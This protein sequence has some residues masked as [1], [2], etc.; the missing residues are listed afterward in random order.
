[1]MLY[2]SEN[3]D[4]PP[5]VIYLIGAIAAIPIVGGLYCLVTSSLPA[6]RSLSGSRM[7][8]GE[9]KEE[10]KEI[11]RKID[12]IDSL[13][14]DVS[15]ARHHLEEGETQKALHWLDP[16]HALG[17]LKKSL[18][19]G[20]LTPIEF[21]KVG[22]AIIKIK[23]AVDSG[24]LAEAHALI[25]PLQEK[26]AEKAYT[27]FRE[28]DPVPEGYINARYEEARKRVVE[29]WRAKGYSEGLIEKAL[30]WADEWTKGIA[31]RFIKDPVMRATVEETL[32][33]EALA[34]S[35]RW[36]EAMVK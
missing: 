18:Q 9:V 36:I 31:R 11:L 15:V 19:S 5:W 34:L 27:T 21:D 22:E 13:Y 35:T 25:V 8:P 6:G 23:D 10:V 3:W 4:S 33:P 12:P 29:E 28:L 7:K 14:F 16:N 26:L 30:L 17:E 20:L 24:R 1:M 2:M 32:Y